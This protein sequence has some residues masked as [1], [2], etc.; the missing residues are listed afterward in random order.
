MAEHNDVVPFGEFLLGEVLKAVDEPPRDAGGVVPAELGSPSGEPDS[1]IGVQQPIEPLSNAVAQEPAERLVPPFTGDFAVSVGQIEPPAV[2]SPLQ[3]FPMRLD[4]EL[5][6]E[7][8]PVPEVVV[9]HEI[10]HRNPTLAKS[11]ESGHSLP[12]GFGNNR[13]I[14]EP[15]VEEVAENNDVRAKSSQCSEKVAEELTPLQVSRV[16]MP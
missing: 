14:I 11:P 1:D 13:T 4:A 3:V 9:A 2:P 8:A 5:I 7:E 10:I 16:A 6:A 12:E 15:E